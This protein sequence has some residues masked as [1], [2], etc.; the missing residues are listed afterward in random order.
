[1]ERRATNLPPQTWEE[2]VAAGAANGTAVTGNPN[3]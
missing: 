2:R 3:V 1:M